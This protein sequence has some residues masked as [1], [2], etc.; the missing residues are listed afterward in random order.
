[1]VINQT[2]VL[3]DSS[4][5]LET[6]KSFWAGAIVTPNKCVELLGGQIDGCQ[7]SNIAEVMAASAALKCY[8]SVHENNSI[9]LVTD[10]DAVRKIKDVAVIKIN[11]HGRVNTAHEHLVSLFKVIDRQAYKI[12]RTSFGRKM[13]SK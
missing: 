10:S 2:Y 3:A 4:Y 13:R 11:K 5:D 12:F 1:M 8:Q 9:S 6:K 7:T